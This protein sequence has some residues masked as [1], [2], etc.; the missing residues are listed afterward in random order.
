MKL[1]TISH[2]LLATAATARILYA[3]IDESGGGFGVY[4]AT[5]TPG[6]GLPGTFGVDYAFI[7]NITVDI[8]DRQNKVCAIC[9]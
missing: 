7:N 9:Y 5:A 6:M 8:Y 1:V 3:V 4:S 2:L